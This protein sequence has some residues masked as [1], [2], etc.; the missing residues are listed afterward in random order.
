MPEDD[1]F[2]SKQH[3]E[4]RMVCTAL[5]GAGFLILPMK[6]SIILCN[7]DTRNEH[8]QTTLKEREAVACKVRQARA[9]QHLDLQHIQ[10]KLNKQIPVELETNNG[11]KQGHVQTAHCNIRNS[12]R[13][14]MHRKVVEDAYP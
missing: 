8:Q 2:V 4:L 7:F 14:C 9:K 11:V 3:A 6:L 13:V 12:K 5:A 10:A 1:Y